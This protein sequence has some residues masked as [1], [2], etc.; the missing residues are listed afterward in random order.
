MIYLGS[1]FQWFQFMVACPMC[2]VAVGAC[3]RNLTLQ[4]TGSKEQG[5]DWGLGIAFK[6]TAPNDVLHP[7]KPYLLKVTEPP[8]IAP[9]AKDQGFNTW[10]YSGN[11]HIQTI[12][13]WV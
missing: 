8:K 4:W 6:D 11:F 10:S 13:V 12:T 2:T 5:S 3:G 9:S 1:W 7:T